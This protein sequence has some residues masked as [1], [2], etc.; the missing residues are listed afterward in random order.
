MT[1]DANFT[2]PDLVDLAVLGIVEESSI[3]IGPLRE[4]V[5]ILCGPWLSPTGEVIE[6]RLALLLWRSCLLDSNDSIAIAPAG[7][8]T[9]EHLMLRPLL[10]QDH[11]L[12]FCA[13]N[14]KLAFLDRLPQPERDA[15]GADLLAARKRCLA[16]VAGMLDGCGSDRP[17]LRSCLSHQR[18]LM[19]AELEVMAQALE[20][21]V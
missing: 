19:T 20:L 6:S 2:V 11:E 12:R 15:V 16:C 14:L 7:R 5:R 10:A 21:G 9:F 18:R 13:E 1:S 3:A 8:A 4:R 17:S